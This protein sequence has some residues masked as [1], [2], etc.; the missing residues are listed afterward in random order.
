MVRYFQRPRCIVQTVQA[1]RWRRYSAL[2]LLAPL[3]WELIGACASS[4]SYL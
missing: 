4:R 2:Q 3:C 1:N